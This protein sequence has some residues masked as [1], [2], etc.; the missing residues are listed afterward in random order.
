[1]Q[2]VHGS[3]GILAA[4]RNAS[5]PFGNARFYR[6][7]SAIGARMG[8]FVFVFSPAHIDW[9]GHRVE[10]YVCKEST[11]SWEKRRL[12]LPDFVYDRFFCSSGNPYALYRKQ[13]R[14]LLASEN[15][16]FLGI[17]LPD[18]Y[19]VQRMLSGDDAIRPFL[20]EMHKIGD[21]RDIR[22]LLAERG[23]LVLKP[24]GGSQG[25][26]IVRLTSCSENNARFRIVGRNFRNE[27]ISLEFGR[28]PELEGWLARFVGRR[29]YV[30]MP[31]LELTTG[32]GQPYDI[33]A[34]VQKN[35]TGRWQW[36]GMAARVGPSGQ[37]TSNLHGGGKAVD[38]MELL[39]AEFAGEAGRLA[40]EIRTLSL[41]VAR[42]LEARHGRLLEIGIDFGI[43]PTGAI[44]LLEVNSRPGR[45]VFRRVGDR[46]AFR[47]A[48][49][50]PIL[51]ACHLRDRQLGG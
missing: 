29:R 42:V 24:S 11:G 44:R 49:S 33:R 1:V 6:L 50:N 48:V 46:E 7:L 45:S 23:D 15:V 8:L 17:G 22:R 13:M 40:E 43:E 32:S 12:P 25:R 31:Y 41:R 38:A 14:R 19:R 2:S 16:R 35:G 4:E 34:F 37:L 30:A 20:A 27:P 36:I 21:L 3:L 9:V 10:G 28:R 51:Y 5:P 18:K 47:R 39:R 26:G